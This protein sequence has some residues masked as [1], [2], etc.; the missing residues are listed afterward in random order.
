MAENQRTTVET[1]AARGLIPYAG[2]I[3]DLS[4]PDNI[5]IFLTYMSQNTKARK[6]SS[7]AMRAFLDGLGSDRIAGALLSDVLPNLL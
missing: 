4:T 6:K 2:D 1:F 5:L 3:R 7:Q